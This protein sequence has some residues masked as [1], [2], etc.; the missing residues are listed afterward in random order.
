[1][2][3][4]PTVSR[5]Y[6][7][8]LAALAGEAKDLEGWGAYMSDVAEACTTD[9]TLRRFLESPRVTA[10]H[11]SKII[12][13]AFSKRLPTKLVR[14]LQ[15]VVMHRRQHLLTDIAVEYM[16]LID[17]VAG[18]VHAQV[19]VASEVSAERKT[20]INKQLSRITGKDVVSHFAVQPRI[21]GGV[22]VKIGDT[23]MDGSVARRLASLRLKML[24]SAAH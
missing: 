18:R 22:V 5:N 6:A 23:V 9:D 2:T 21:L 14:F 1:M 11:K 8:V 16:A 19:Q 3:R 24:G 7:E 13:D 17:E 12:G 4:E 10:A 15:A 20:A